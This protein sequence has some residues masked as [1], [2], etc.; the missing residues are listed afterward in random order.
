MG[1]TENV[2]RAATGHGDLRLYLFNK[3]DA[4]G[5]VTPVMRNEEYIAVQIDSGKNQTIL[6]TLRN[7]RRQQKT[8]PAEG[9][10]QNEGTVIGRIKE[11]GGRHYD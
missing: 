5:T 8:D 4:A 7:V 9:E 11:P 3:G 1:K 2:F 6:D 10:F